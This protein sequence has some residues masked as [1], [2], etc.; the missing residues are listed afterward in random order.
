[1]QKKDKAVKIAAA[2]IKDFEG[3]SLKPYK[4]LAGVLT[5]GYGNT[6]F[7]KNYKVS[8]AE[9]LKKADTYEDR[10]KELYLRM[11]GFKADDIKQN[12]K[13]Q[14]VVITKQKAED[15]LLKDISV[16]FEPIWQRLGT[17]CNANQLA[18]LTSLAYNIGIGAFLESK[19]YGLVKT[20]PQNYTA[21]EQEFLKWNKVNNK[22]LKGLANRRVK[23][24][25]LYRL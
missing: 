19:L 22:P 12:N 15:L 18:S 16:F 9:P 1:M 11:Q 4:C 14:D 21:I 8:K 13:P 10:L 7:L 3:L 23:E 5:I 2:I 25:N 6:S 24:F 20:N 17:Q